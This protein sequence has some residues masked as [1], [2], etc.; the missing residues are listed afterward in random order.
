M[1]LDLPRSLPLNNKLEVSK[2]NLTTFKNLYPHYQRAVKF[3][4]ITVT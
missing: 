3:T 2:I 1:F 4:L